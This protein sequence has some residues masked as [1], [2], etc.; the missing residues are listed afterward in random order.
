MGLTE[1]KKMENRSPDSRGKEERALMIVVMDG[2]PLEQL[3]QLPLSVPSAFCSG[4]WYPGLP[5]S[6]S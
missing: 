5:L 1:E 2:V 4:H 3:R 6:G